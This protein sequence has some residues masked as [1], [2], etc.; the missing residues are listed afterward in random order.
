ML[1]TVIDKPCVAVLPRL[2]VTLTVK[3]KVPVAL[4]FPLIKP[5]EI[6]RDSQLG[7]DPDGMDQI[8]GASPPETAK[9]AL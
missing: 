2:S 5:V 1:V 9:V 8:H 4:G 3:L 7:R 6:F